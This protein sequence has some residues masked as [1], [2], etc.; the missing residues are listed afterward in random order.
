[1]KLRIKSMIWNVRKQ[2]LTNQNYKK[3]QSKKKNNKDSVKSLWDNFKHSNKDPNHRDAR[4]RSKKSKKLAI[5]L[6]K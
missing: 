6:K 3:K 1:M 2:N 5:Y 4:K